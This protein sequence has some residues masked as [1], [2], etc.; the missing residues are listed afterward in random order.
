MK[1]KLLGCTWDPKIH[2]TSCNKPRRTELSCEDLKPLFLCI[3][4]VASLGSICA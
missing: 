3:T 4:L 2:G 1:M